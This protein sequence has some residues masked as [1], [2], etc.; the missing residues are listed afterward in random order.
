M[1]A[2]RKSPI[3]REHDNP[4]SVRNLDDI[5]FPNSPMEVHRDFT[6]FGKEQV[7][8]WHVYVE[9]EWYAKEETLRNL[10]TRLYEIIASQGSDWAYPSTRVNPTWPAWDRVENLAFMGELSVQLQEMAFKKDPAL[11][12]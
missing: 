6:M 2:K 1:T 3:P 10:S 4:H 7:Y 12:D 9:G 5:L 8:E 11:Q